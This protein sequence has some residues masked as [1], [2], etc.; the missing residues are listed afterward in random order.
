M[1]TQRSILPAVGIL[2]VAALAGCLAGQPASSSAGDG[3]IEPTGETKVFDLYL[4]MCEITPY[5]N[6]TFMQW[7]VSET[8][9]P[10]DDTVPGPTI[11]VTAGDMV[12]IRLHNEINEWDHTLHWH[13]LHVPWKQ[14]GVP[15][16]TQ[17]PVSPG[18]THEYSFIAKPSGTFWYHGHSGEHH[19]DM[20]HWGAFIVDPQDG[21]QIDYDREKTLILSGANKYHTMGINPADSNIPRNS[22]PLAYEDWSRS[23]VHQLTRNSQYRDLA[24]STPLQEDRDWW[25]VT[26]E[27]YSPHYNTFMINGRSFPW[28]PPVFIEEGET[29]RMRLVSV[30]QFVTWHLHGHYMKITHLDGAPVPEPYLRDT[31]MVAPGQRVSVLV[32]GDNPGIWAMHSHTPGHVQNDQIYPGG[33]LTT[34]VYEQFKDQAFQSNIDPPNAT[35]AAGQFQQLYR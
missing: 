30:N 27:P 14:D 20:G 16:I 21:P 3:A 2:L 22:D 8:S 18:E 4:S 25:P 10:G 35:F 13:G 32:E 19:L 33:M 11:R 31:I 6:T 7:C 24:T 12:K 26:R 5:P 29:L 17:D 9:D 1:S 15:Y 23:Q 28:S 34:L